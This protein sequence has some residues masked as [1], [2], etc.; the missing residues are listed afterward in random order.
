[1]THIFFFK[2]VILTLTIPSLEMLKPALPA[3]KCS[4]IRFQTSEFQVLL[5]LIVLLVLLFQQKLF[6]HW[7]HIVGSA[8]SHVLSKAQ[9][10]DFSPRCLFLLPHVSW[11]I[12]RISVTPTSY[13]P[14]T[15][16]ISL[17]FCSSISWLLKV[18][19]SRLFFSFSDHFPFSSQIS[20]SPPLSRE[21]VSSHDFFPS[22]V[23]CVL[24]H[25]IHSHRFTY[26]LSHVAPKF[27]FMVPL[28]L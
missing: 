19:F 1:V 3:R 4:W 13:S 16:S 14:F 6:D 18:T 2:V 28:C 9:S 23:L 24:G 26:H 22:P 27:K 11:P 10:S 25:L 12:C 21:E 7:E 5:A 17:S 20:P 8:S 15:F